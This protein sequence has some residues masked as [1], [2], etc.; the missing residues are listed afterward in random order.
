M[1]RKKTVFFPL[2]L[3]NRRSLQEF[4]F[5]SEVPSR[6]H[7][8]FHCKHR[9][10]HVLLFFFLFQLA[11]LQF[12]WYPTTNGGMQ[13]GSSVEIRTHSLQVFARLAPICMV[14]GCLV[15]KFLHR[16]LV[17]FI[18]SA[19]LVG[20]WCQ[21]SFWC[22]F[23]GRNTTLISLA[24][25]V[26]LGY[27]RTHFPQDSFFPFYFLGRNSCWTTRETCSKFLK[28]LFFFQ[29]FS[30]GKFVVFLL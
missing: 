25:L 23:L 21:V 27:Q 24:L 2:L 7:F 15:T 30:V 11:M 6:D 28:Y 5:V 29:K 17:G 9:R 8:L 12:Y 1:G 22:L 13:N 19:L 26:F 14:I 20:W 4:F 3:E 16:R 18:N 10:Q